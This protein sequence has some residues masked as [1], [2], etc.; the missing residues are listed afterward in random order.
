MIR[1]RG[2]ALPRRATAMIGS[3]RPVSALLAALLLAGPLAACE[4]GPP[5][6]WTPPRS[7]QLA[8]GAPEEVLPGVDLSSLTPPQRQVV[9]DW[10]QATFSY[11]G[12]PRTVAASL[13]AGTSCRHAPRMAGLA[14]RLAASGLDR[15]KLSRALTDYYASFRPEKRARLD[16]A[17]F[18]PPLGD[19]SAPVALVEFSDFTCP[20]CQLLRPELEKFVAD[21]PGRVRLHFK[22]FPIE[23]HEHAL[24]SAQ[25]AEWARDQGAF[26]KVHDALFQDPYSNDPDSLAATATALGLDGADLA[27]ALKAERLLPRV[28]ASMAEA[29][30]AGITGTPTLFFNGRM[31]RGP[32]FSEADLA[33]A[34]EDEEEWVKHGGWARD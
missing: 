17:A 25:A 12:A 27:A 23:S 31:H 22:P 4:S 2:G 6:A 18:G 15:E 30:A 1:R 19:A 21:R 33:F 34:L 29:R 10:A 16:V 8:A 11:C 9:A 13:Q 26:W 28:R 32:S 20:F 3:D 14:V 5:R 7:T 24:E